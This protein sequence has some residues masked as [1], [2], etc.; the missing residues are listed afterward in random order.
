M[1]RLY[2]RS[3][4]GKRCHDTTPHGRWCS[5]S[6]IASMR[7][8]GFTTQTALSRAT[9]TEIFRTSV[10]TGR[11]RNTTLP[12]GNG[13]LPPIEAVVNSIQAIEE[14]AGKFGSPLPSIIG[15]DYC[16]LKRLSKFLLIAYIEQR[17][18][19]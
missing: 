4:R 11:P 2:G 9:N 18:T 7:S 13:L 14:C 16:G 3:R 15:E 5:T 1:T 12:K 17:L 6:M 10:L 19:L 8:D